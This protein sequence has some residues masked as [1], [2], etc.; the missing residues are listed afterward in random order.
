MPALLQQRN[1]VVDRQHDVSDELVLSHL[2]VSDSDTHAQHLLQLE[3]DGGLDLGDLGGQVVGV[4][5]GSREFT[6]CD[7]P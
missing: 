6:S 4:R 5:D 7:E 1:Q 2:N 3:F